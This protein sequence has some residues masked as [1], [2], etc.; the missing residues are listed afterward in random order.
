ME[1]GKAG[2]FMMFAQP[3]NARCL[4]RTDCFMINEKNRFGK[5]SVALRLREERRAY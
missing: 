4:S 1:D 3:I 5:M 2:Q